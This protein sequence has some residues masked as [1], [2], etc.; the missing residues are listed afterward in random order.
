MTGHGF[1]MRIDSARSPLGG[2]SY[3]KGTVSLGG[4]PVWTN[5]STHPDRIAARSWLWDD[6]ISALSR[7]LADA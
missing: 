3:W 2:T 4:R 5:I 7:A 6:F 1:D